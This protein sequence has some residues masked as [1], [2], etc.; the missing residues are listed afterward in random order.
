MATAL[1]VP[2]LLTIGRI[3]AIPVIC[4]CA[5]LG[6]AWG[7][8]L[9]FA[10][11]VLAAITDWLD[12]YLARAWNQGSAL[13]RMLDPIAD[14]ALVAA[15]LVVLAWTHALSGWDLV[16]ALAILLREILVSGLREYLGP[17]GVVVHVTR[18][19]KWKTTVQLVALA[20]ILLAGVF[21]VLV[22]P[23]VL[24]LWL[25]GILTV[26]TGYEYY[27]GAWLHLTGEPT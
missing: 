14:K 9:A 25:A 16:P 20:A 17:K 19:A 2:N 1:N 7:Y 8:G 11:F 23:G 10:L 4:L 21:P 26:W 12:G 3:V 6:G 15:L 27:R 22:V 13:G 18:L 5:V 24:L